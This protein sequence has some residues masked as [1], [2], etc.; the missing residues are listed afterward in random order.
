MFWCLLVGEEGALGQAQVAPHVMYPPPFAI[1]IRRPVCGTCT[2]NSAKTLTRTESGTSLAY[3]WR[4]C[5]PSQTSFPLTLATPQVPPATL[6]TNQGQAVL[7]DLATCFMVGIMGWNIT[8]CP[9]EVYPFRFVP[10]AGTYSVL[11]TTPP[12]PTGISPL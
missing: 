5:V 10:Y 9:L 2:E 7:V 8:I 4:H 3:R 1:S 12:T 11:S 6:E